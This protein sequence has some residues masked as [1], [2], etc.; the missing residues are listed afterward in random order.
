MITPTGGYLE[1]GFGRNTFVL[2]A[3]IKR[4]RYIYRTPIGEKMEKD[5]SNIVPFAG[6]Q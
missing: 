3:D 4:F 2:V 6:I 5:D 1:D